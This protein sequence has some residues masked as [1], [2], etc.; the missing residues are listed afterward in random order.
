[1]ADAPTSF[2]DFERQGWSA[3]EIVA[4]YHDYLSPLTRQTIGALLDAA[5]VGRGTRVVDVATGA[6][7]AA[8]AA[9]DRDA[10][11]VGIDFSPTQL[12]LARQRCS[13]VEFYD[14]EADTL[15]F[16]DGRFDAVISNF[17]VPHFPDPDAFFREAFRVLRNGGRLAFSVWAS[18]QQSDGFGIIYGAVQAY[19][20]L[21]VPLPSGPNFFLFSDPVQCERS[22][23]SAGFQSVSVTTVP[24]VWRVASP[25]VPFEAL[26]RGSV[27]AAA[28]LRAQT[29]EA[30]TAIREAIRRE[31]AAHARAGQ[32]ELPMSA[33]VAAAERS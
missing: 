2:R 11:V 28:L 5:G 9:A 8:A 20:R 7:Y 14:A 27:R 23:Q 31:V 21:D 12:T 16:P 33:I 1:M 15:P 19:G 30:L 4:G 29:P 24:Q 10:A 3:A 18:P 32:I 13:A 25:G 26:M 22:L 17:G 6:G